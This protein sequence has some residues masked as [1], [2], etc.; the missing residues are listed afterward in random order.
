MT[1]EENKKQEEYLFKIARKVLKWGEVKYT[2]EELANLVMLELLE[3]EEKQDNNMYPQQ[4]QYIKT[5]E[6]AQ[7]FA[8]DWQNWQAD[9]Q[10]LSY[11]ELIDW[12]IVL[13][14]LADKYDLR[15][16]FEENCII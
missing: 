6:E 15:E 4:A 12:Q 2:E 5:K 10:D 11:G 8:I 3:K 1:Q 9:K 7:Q 13:E 14:N 16:E